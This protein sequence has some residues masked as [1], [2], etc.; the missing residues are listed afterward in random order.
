MYSNYFIKIGWFGD[1]A[2]MYQLGFQDPATTAMEGIYLFNIH[3]LF[4]II[5]I[6]LLVAWLLFII[7]RNFTESTSS[8]VTNF[9]HS[10]YIEIL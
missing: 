5:T 2:V 6:V 3:L 8:S 7:L 9:T 4:I 1:S 10:K